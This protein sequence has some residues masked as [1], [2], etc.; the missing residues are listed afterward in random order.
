VHPFLSPPPD[1][2]TDEQLTNE[3]P[4]DAALG[5]VDY[6]EVVGFADHRASAEVWYRLLNCG[7]RIAAAGGTDA[8]A[9]YAS[10]RGPVGLNRTYVRTE[11]AD[12]S[13]DARRDGWLD[14]LASG[15]SMATNAPLIGLTVD[16]AHP[17]DVISLADGGRT[18]R[19]EGFLRSAVAV[20]HLELVHNGKVIES[21]DIDAGGDSADIE[22]QVTVESSGWLLLRAWN[23]AADPLVFDLYPYA[24][25][26][27]VYLNVG[28][29]PPVSPDDAAYFLAWIERI[30]DFAMSHDDYNF[31]A[32]R[33]AILEHIRQATRFYEACRQGGS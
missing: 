25:T 3:L 11:A 24:T 9:N 12:D 19:F 10:L 32:E 2:R 26:S 1:P 16:D 31:A 27:P 28:D 20:D 23:D 29:T 21:F 22:G 7:A 15:R 6:Y 30:R 14:G 8:M 5:L 18:L 17:G 13:P 33:D 4:V